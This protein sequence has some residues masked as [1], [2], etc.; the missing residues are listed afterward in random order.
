MDASSLRLCNLVKT[1]VYQPGMAAFFLAPLIGIDE[2]EEII[3]G[4]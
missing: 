1:G 4:I 3:G 2:F